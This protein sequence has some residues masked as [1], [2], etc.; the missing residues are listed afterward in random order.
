MPIYC[1]RAY[2]NHVTCARFNRAER[3]RM[4]Q[5]PEQLL[6]FSSHTNVLFMEDNQ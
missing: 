1:I 3:E 6:F 5:N 2:T 4:T